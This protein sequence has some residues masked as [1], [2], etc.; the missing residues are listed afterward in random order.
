MITIMLLLFIDTCI[1]PQLH[2]LMDILADIAPQYHLIGVA[3]QVPMHTLGLHPLPQYHKKNLS[4][5]LQWWLDNGPT[6]GSPVTYD[7]IINAVKGRIVDNLRVSEKLREF[8]EKL[9]EESKH[10]SLFILPFYVMIFFRST[11]SK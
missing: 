9:L 5:T 7:N 6:V 10:N 1:T 3:L 2:H 11:N 8:Y 4:Q